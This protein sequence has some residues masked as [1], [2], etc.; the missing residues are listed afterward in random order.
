VWASGTES[1]CLLI[2]TCYAPPSP[3][4]VQVGAA[5]A[6]GAAA[7][8]RTRYFRS[9]HMPL[10]SCLVTIFAF[11]SYWLADGLRLSGI[12]SVLFCGITAAHYVRP[13]MTPR[14][15][16]RVGSLFKLLAAL[17]ETSV[18]LFIGSSLFLDQQE[19]GT[20]GLLPFLVSAGGRA[21]AGAAAAAW[22]RSS[23]PVGLHVEGQ[24]HSQAC[25][26]MLSER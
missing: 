11:A 26:H 7:L 10:E 9:E 5:V 6:F 8:V 21:G 18:F 20:W 23:A 12:V 3:P 16:D 15:C 13:N 2:L 14:G 17:A 22:R 4:N 24:L 25:V 19:L 1:T